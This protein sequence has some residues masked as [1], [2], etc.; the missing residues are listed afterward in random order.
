MALLTFENGVGLRLFVR[1]VALDNLLSPPNSH[2][3]DALLAR[4]FI[5]TRSGAPP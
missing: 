3:A 1:R 5:K 4:F 2:I